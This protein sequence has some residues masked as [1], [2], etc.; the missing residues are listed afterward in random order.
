[1]AGAGKSEAARFFE[2]NGY[3]RIRFGDI[4]DTEILK[5]GLEIN[6]DNE[7]VVRETLRREHGMAAYAVLNRPGIDRALDD[8][9]VVIDGLY[10]WEEYKSLKQHYGQNLVVVAVIASPAIRHHRLGLRKIR[11]SRNRKPLVA[12]VQK[13]K[14]LTKAAR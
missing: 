8:S 9:P 10:S 14:T 3:K 13:S 4:T 7:R 1:M 11:R 12:I 6:E 2:L 5:R